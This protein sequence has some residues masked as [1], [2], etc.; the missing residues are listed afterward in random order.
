[1]TAPQLRHFN[2]MESS[3]IG[4]GVTHVG[5][6][7]LAIWAWRVGVRQAPFFLLSFGCLFAGSLVTA[8][9][10]LSD[11][12]M[13]NAAMMGLMLGSALEML[14]LSL[15]VADRFA[16][17]QSEK[18]EAQAGLIEETER[19]RAVEEAYADELAVEVRERTR[20]LEAA[21][22]DKD[23]VLAV[24]GHDLR[25]PLTGLTQ[26]A[27]QVAATPADTPALGKFAGDAATMGRQ[28]LLLI[29][30]LVLWARLRAGLTP[31]PGRHRAS[32]I[33]APVVALHRAFAGQRGIKLVVT[34]PDD[35]RVAT[36]LVLAQTLLRNLVANA[37]K[38][39]RSEVA[40]D[41]AARAES[42]GG[43]VQLTV[44]DDGPGLPAAVLAGLAAELPAQTGVEGGLGLRLCVEIS[45]A[46]GAK[47]EAA[48]VVGRGTE[49]KFVL[50]AAG[51]GTN[52]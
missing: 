48:S 27:E 1:V 36:D 41:A 14:M 7:A 42:A 31:P 52:P 44:R 6:F 15:A 21:N 35:L 34:V 23:R 38:F 3:V 50:P 12:P 17:T 4:V 33:V 28:V 2:W 9:I 5:L 39:A 10:W 8:V 13:K 19:R 30:D 43:G 29:E 11:A 51:D 45:R 18:A 49:F 32:A 20:E 22:A 47:L 25:S 26:A 40:V 24:I 16:R 46:L 37:L